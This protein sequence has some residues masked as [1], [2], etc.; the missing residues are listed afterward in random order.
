[1][2]LYWIGLVVGLLVGGG[3]TPAVGQSSADALFHDAAQR[4]VAGDTEAARRA[5]ER[6]LE[7]APSDPRLRALRKTL[8]Q[9]EKRRGGGRPSP[10][11][12][13]SQTQRDPS[14][15]NEGS[16]EQSGA[17]GE[18]SQSQ[19]DAPSRSEAS[20]SG[21]PDPSSTGP[22]GAKAQGRQ[23]G[24]RPGA[25]RSARR[26]SQAQAARLLQALE[27]QEQ[28]LLREVQGE[29]EAPRRVEKDW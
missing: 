11:G 9:H 27:N 1:M 18:G 2:R 7:I 5:V 6:G 8:E 3:G 25:R 14:R 19:S 23:G 13:Q 21:T 16:Q 20:P 22:S 17:S 12:Q 26:L 28:K 10:Q 15:G 4:Y 24:D 29:S